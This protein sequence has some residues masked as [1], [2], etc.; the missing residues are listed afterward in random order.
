[1][2]ETIRAVLTD[3]DV[4]GYV[5]LGERELREA[6]SDDVVIC[7]ER[8]SL[9]RGEVRFASGKP[10]GT[11]I[12][13]D[14]AGTV[15]SGAGFEPGTRVV[16]FVRA[17][18]GWAQKVVVPARDVAPV[19]SDVSLDIAAALPVAAGTALAA[20]DAGGDGLIGRRALVTGVTGGVGGFA[21]QLARA[22][23]TTVV[24]QVRQQ[25]QVKYA[26]S[27]G[28][29]QVVVTSD[30]SELADV[31]GFRLVVDGIGGQLLQRA[32][33]KLDDDGVAVAYGVTGSPEIALPLGA[34]LGKGRA[35]IRGLNLYAVSDVI[36]PSARLPRLLELVARN[37][38]VA[39]IV[40]RGSWSNVARVCDDLIERR[41]QGKAVLHVD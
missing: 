35:T 40:D 31:E 30:G 41:F 17:Q 3:P 10:S 29:D 5:R 20:I 39:D 28:A 7:V 37:R 26:E 32:I 36:P 15:E 4:K 25:A 38:L 1:M 27:L 23:G 9:N 8:F 34:M 22:A 16:A 18:D 33:A 14:V 19:P 24:A 2:S 21:V 13:W 6:G 11:P 12:G